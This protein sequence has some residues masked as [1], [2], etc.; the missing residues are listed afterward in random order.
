[1]KK[2]LERRDAR[3]YLAG[4]SL[5]LLGDTS[6]WLAAG[7]FV[8][9]ITK[10]NSAAG[11]VFF[12]YALAS[13]SAPFAGMLVD[14]VKRRPL[15]ITVNLLTAAAVMLML[16][17]HSSHDVW[18]VYL[19]MVLYGVSG[20]LISSGQSAF[21]TVLLP[22]ELLGDAN[23]F[24]STVREG[25]RLI[26]PL[27]G[28][29]L[30]VLVGMGVVASID[31]A[32]FVIAAIAVALV[33]TEEPTPVRE[34]TKFLRE[35]SEGFRH[36]FRTPILRRTSIALAVAL[37]FVGF[38]ETAAFAVV[39]FG[40]HRPPSFLGVILAVQ[41]VG[42]LVGGL[43]SAHALRKMGEPRLVGF[44]LLGAAVGCLL[45]IVPSVVAVCA[46]AV[47]FGAALP[48]L[49]VGAVTLLQRRTPPELQGRAYSAFDLLA[50]VPQT[51]SIG[52]GA[53]IIGV[54][55]YQPELMM[56]AVAITGSA[57]IMLTVR[58]EGPADDFGEP[59]TIAAPDE[60]LGLAADNVI[61]L[62]GLAMDMPE[63]ELVGGG[64]LV[65]D[66]G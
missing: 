30:F 1:M 35:A 4:Q 60:L 27:V 41:G 3:I 14:R 31:A 18:I 37:L 19:V 20:A 6:L 33:R 38:G 26:A 65:V 2:L 63:P 56:M 61:P 28:A 36:V 32:T 34:D 8:K 52:V 51:I 66:F 21:M 17:V 16:L 39:G 64:R 12:F 53:L 46:G 9:T 47:V 43:S 62:P 44:G 10:S 58:G 15:L 25:L 59:A 49:I 5:S 11:L 23:G 45:W 50:S 22:S 7:I 55:G 29:G 13:L 40:L 54:V 24:L 57:A 48:W 42:A